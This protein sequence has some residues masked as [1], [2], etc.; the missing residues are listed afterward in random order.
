M[1][2]LP[3][4]EKVTSPSRKVPNPSR[5]PTV[6]ANV[7]AH[8]FIGI[9]IDLSVL[10]ARIEGDVVPSESLIFVREPS[11]VLKVDPSTT[12]RP[13]VGL[14]SPQVVDFQLSGP[15]KFLKGLFDRSVAAFVLLALSPLLL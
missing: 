1:D 4:L 10:S 11:D 15:Q 9:Y 12:I 14:T 7:L 8:A 13:T 2:T 3:P 5:E 6:V